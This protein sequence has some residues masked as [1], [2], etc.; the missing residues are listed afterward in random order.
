[1][2]KILQ[3]IVFPILILIGCVVIMIEA[4]RDLYRLTEPKKSVFIVDC[5][6]DLKDKKD[7]EN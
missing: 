5:E 4:L 1:M 6:C 3:K 7:E 2:L